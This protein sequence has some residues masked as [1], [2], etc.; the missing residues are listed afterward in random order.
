MRDSLTY[1]AILEE[2]RE[3]GQVRGERR[4][5]LRM[6][7]TRLGPP[8]DVTRAQIESISDIN[9]LD[10]LTDRVLTISSWSELLADQ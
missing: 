8:D 10:L 7:T 1:Q 6:G 4:A 3:E 2:G 9:T 5:L